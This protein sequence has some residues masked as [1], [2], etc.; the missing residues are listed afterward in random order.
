MQ[1]PLPPV[2]LI[3]DNQADLSFNTSQY[4]DS[5]DTAAHQDFRQ[6]KPESKCQRN[7]PSKRGGDDM[8]YE[9]CANPA[10]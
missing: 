4:V 1:T 2:L 7:L 3:N 6:F 10:H 9:F 8:I 5:A